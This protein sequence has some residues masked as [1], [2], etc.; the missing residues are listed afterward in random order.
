[1]SYCKYISNYISNYIWSNSKI[2]IDNT[3]SNFYQFKKNECAVY[4]N[5]KLFKY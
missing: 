5:D 4:N 2:H 1:M 3:T